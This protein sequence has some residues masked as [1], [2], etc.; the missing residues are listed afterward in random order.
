M[1][2]EQFILKQIYISEREECCYVASEEASL[3]SAGNSF[4]R[5][6]TSFIPFTPLSPSLLS[7]LRQWF[8]LTNLFFK[9]HSLATVTVWVVHN[10]NTELDNIY[11]QRRERLY[12][13]DRCSSMH[14]C[15]EMAM[16]IPYPHH[17]VPIRGGQKS[18]NQKYSLVLTGMFRF[19]PGTQILERFHIEHGGYH[20]DEFLWIH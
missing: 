9:W 5:K 12:V 1:N 6:F 13:C 17:W 7:P 15:A 2:L 4:L 20:F 19:I 10:I 14:S 8:E 18:V 11:T 3:N 16:V